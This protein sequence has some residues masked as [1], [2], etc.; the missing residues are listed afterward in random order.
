V[1][2]VARRACC[3]NHPVLRAVAGRQI[4]CRHANPGVELAEVRR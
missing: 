2:V 4:R 1:A 3:F